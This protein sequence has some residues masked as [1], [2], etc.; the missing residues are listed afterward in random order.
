MAGKSERTNEEKLTSFGFGLGKNI[1]LAN[2]LTCNPEISIQYLY[3]GNWDRYN[4]VYK[5]DSPLTFRIFKGVAL[6]AGPSFNLFSSER[7]D[8]NIPDINNSVFVQNRT[9]R[10]NMIKKNSNLITGWIG[11]SF[12]LN[13]F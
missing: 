9:K 11:W 1:L 8:K 3:L 5:F 6:S 2:R 12:G 10:Y 4:F 13:L 7:I